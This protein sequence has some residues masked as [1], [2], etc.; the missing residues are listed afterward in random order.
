MKLTKRLL[1]VAF[2]PTLL[3]VSCNEDTTENSDQQ[4]EMSL[5]D[6]YDVFLARLNSA[7][8][9]SFEKENKETLEYCHKLGEEFN[10]KSEKEKDETLKVLMVDCP[11][12][13]EIGNFV[14]EEDL[15]QAEETAKQLDEALELDDITTPIS[16][17]S[18]ENTLGIDE[19][20][21]PN[22]I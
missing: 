16:S 18:L 21:D 8:S 2:V 9:K 3:L 15:K 4:E 20:F 22:D 5:C 17:D 19:E 6:C 14:T 7:D 13:M 10:H 1:I 12:F 11:A